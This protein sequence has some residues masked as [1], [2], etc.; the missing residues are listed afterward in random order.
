MSEEH[1]D[2]YSALLAAQPNFKKPKKTAENKHFGNKYAD[3]EADLDAV[4]PALNAEGIVYQSKIVANELGHEVHTILRHP[5][6]GTDDTFACPLLMSKQ[7]MQG[8]KSAR[9][10]ARRIGIEDI[11]GIATGEDDDA[12]DNRQNANMGAAIRDAWRQSVEDNMPDNAT[13]RQKAEAY[14][15]AICEDFQGKGEKAL[16]NRW[17]KHK[18]LIGQF[19]QRFTDLHEKVVDAFENEM[20]RATGNDVPQQHA[21]ECGPAHNG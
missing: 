2:I 13:P 15:E 8:L 1:K 12:E 6:S 18:S 20:M 5:A 21:A 3:L 10:Y 4:V 11:C 19:E 7:D 17:N 14:A 9:T 16:K